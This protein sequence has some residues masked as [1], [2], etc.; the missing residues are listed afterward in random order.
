MK[1]R[2]TGALAALTLGVAAMGGGV[3]SAATV[4]ESSIGDFSNIWTAPTQING[5]AAS[6][7][8]GAGDTL[9]VF[10]FLGL[11]PAAAFFDLTLKLVST[12]GVFSNAGITVYYAFTPFAGENHSFHPGSW[13][14][15][16][17]YQTQVSVA[18]NPWNPAQTGSGAFNFGL[19][20]G[21]SG[22]LHVG[23]K[24]TNGAATDF[25][26]RVDT[27]AQVLTVV[28]VPAS[29]LLMASVLGLLGGIVAL[30]RRRHRV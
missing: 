30:R 5:T 28:P 6:G 9:D 4:S 7:T 27:P 23:L 14:S 15:A 18:F 3:A 11:D 1:T 8:I 29:G 16:P 10:S 26:V 22:D 25:L 21:F 20:A 17:V 19:G 12:A 24:L 2:V 13:V